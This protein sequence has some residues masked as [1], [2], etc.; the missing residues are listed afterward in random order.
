MIHQRACYE[1]VPFI[2][3]VIDFALKRAGFMKWLWKQ[4]SLEKARARWRKFFELFVETLIKKNSRNF[5]MVKKQ[6]YE[7]GS[8]WN[9]LL[10]QHFFFEHSSRMSFISAGAK[11]SWFVSKKKLCCKMQPLP[12]GWNQ[13][14]PTYHISAYHIQC[15][16]ALMQKLWR[17]H[18][19]LTS[20]KN[21]WQNV[22]ILAD[23]K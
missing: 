6:T 3:R 12:S 15:K 14:R 8:V 16:E 19:L 4:Q 22:T 9:N 18:T 1:V 17:R 21:N 11:M 10:E 7:Y 2:S 23:K 20:G 5:Q 13:Q